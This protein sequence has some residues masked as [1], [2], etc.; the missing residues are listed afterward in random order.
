MSWLA[1]AACGLALYV[2]A[3]VGVFALLPAGRA[4]RWG[5]RR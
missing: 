2:A 4:N 1:L 5:A 3:F